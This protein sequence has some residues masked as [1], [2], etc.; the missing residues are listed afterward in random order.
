M[1]G[2]SEEATSSVWKAM[3]NIAPERYMLFQLLI[4][5]SSVVPTYFLP[6][7]SKRTP[8]SC[9]AEMPCSSSHGDVPFCTAE[10]GWSNCGPCGLRSLRSK[11]TMAAEVRVFASGDHA[12]E[13]YD[14]DSQTIVFG[15]IGFLEHKYIQLKFDSTEVFD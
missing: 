9:L 1:F 4:L 5:S 7:G 10:K 3:T 8:F 11:A 12:S 6:I 15:P 13:E 14:P 2:V